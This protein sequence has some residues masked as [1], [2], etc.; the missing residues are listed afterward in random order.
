MNRRTSLLT[1]CFPNPTRNTALSFHY[2]PGSFPLFLLHSLAPFLAS[3]V[4]LFIPVIT[5][6]PT[7]SSSPSSEPCVGIFP[8]S[9]GD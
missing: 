8:Q 3:A 2:L 4:Q 7:S 5:T 6:W 1:C 9:K